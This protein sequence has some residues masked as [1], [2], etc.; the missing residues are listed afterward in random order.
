MKFRIKEVFGGY[1]VQ[2]QINKWYG[3]KWVTYI[4]YTGL[5]IPYL[6]KTREAA[7]RELDVC[8]QKEVNLFLINE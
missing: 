1:L 7:K 6:F 2:K 4:F 3:K 5:E 8:V